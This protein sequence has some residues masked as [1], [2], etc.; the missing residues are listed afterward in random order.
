[1]VLLLGD[2][3]PV[4]SNSR[5][6][7][8][9]ILHP[10]QN[11]GN[12]YT[13]F[14]YFIRNFLKKILVL[15]VILT[16]IYFALQG[17]YPQWYKTRHTKFLL[18][19]CLTISMRIRYKDKYRKQS[20]E[21]S[22]VCLQVMFVGHRFEFFI[23]DLCLVPADWTLYKGCRAV[24]KFPSIFSASYHPFKKLNFSEMI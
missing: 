12:A 10:A 18:E 9:I 16:E 23:G 20:L 2:N 11:W 15:K 22:C 7:E 5:E 1:M 19:D 8:L 6:S 4:N 17:W 13:F 3:F 21:S 14:H 24:R